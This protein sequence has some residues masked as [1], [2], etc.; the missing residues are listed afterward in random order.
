MADLRPAAW[1]RELPWRRRRA[2]AATFMVDRVVNLFGVARNF[3]VL[4]DESEKVRRLMG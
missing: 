2:T 1:P 3:C 4:D